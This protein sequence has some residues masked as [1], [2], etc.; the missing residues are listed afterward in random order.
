M[1][2]GAR[3][4]RLTGLRRLVARAQARDLRAFVVPGPDA[5]GRLG[6]DVEAVGMSMASTP[7]DAGVLLLVGDFA[8]RLA[9]S[10]AVVYAQMMR[11]RVILAL[12]CETADP[13]PSAD[14]HADLSQEGLQ[15][16]V[17]EVRAAL[18]GGAFAHQVADFDAPL[19]HVRIEYVCP[20]HPEVVSEEPGS[21][22]KCGMSLVAHEAGGESEP[23]DAAHDHGGHDHGEHD[24]TDQDHPTHGQTG[25][26]RDHG[27][28]NH[29]GSHGSH[30]HDGSHG[31]HD[32]G[33]HEHG[34]HDHGDSDFMSMVEV[35]QDLPRSADGL[36]MDWIEV[37]FGPFFPGLP[38]GLCVMLTLDGDGV[39]EGRAR[40]LP[41]PDD[42]CADGGVSPSE[43]VD[44]MAAVTPLAPVAWR[45]IACRALED[46]AGTVVE[47]ATA[48]ARVGALE[49]ERIISHLGWLVLLGRQIGFDAW[50]RHAAVL[51]RR[52]LTAGPDELAAMRPEVRKLVNRFE[53]T[54]LVARR[55]ESIGVADADATLRGPVARAAGHEEDLRSSDPA[56]V[57]LEFAPALRTGGDA[58][59]RARVRFDE[60]VASIDLVARCGVSAAAVEPAGGDAS[61]QGTGAVETPRGRAELSV[62]LEAGRVTAMA[63]DTP[64]SH[65]IG[66][67]PRL[68]A[69]QEL[70]DAL[71]AVGSLDLSPWEVRQ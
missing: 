14:V 38:G 62:T 23:G 19:L 58:L 61:G 45:V 50:M 66:L 28:H 11:P 16:G 30:N 20:M 5:A 24:H 22:P 18:A 29:D 32:H 40:S 21:C 6:L 56:Y 42:P 25:Q 41:R 9:E 57:A 44:R 64:C 70:G 37:A 31:S 4:G 46:A 27:D 49:R 63:L 68:V 1:I 35:T 8:G 33:G 60:I 71:V 17:H 39:A 15:T 2:A 34:G 51:Q 65:H 43:F 67:V 26:G 48:R 36:A 3:E 55:L 7:R 54:P 13:L 59:D 47:E 69:G 12:G 52:A 53:R 10:A